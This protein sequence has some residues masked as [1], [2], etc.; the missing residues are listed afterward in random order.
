MNTGGGQP[1]VHSPRGVCGIGELR[2]DCAF[3]EHVIR[4]LVCA[5]IPWERRLAAARAPRLAGFGLKPY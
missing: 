3:V 2:P 5:P 4:N 1:Y